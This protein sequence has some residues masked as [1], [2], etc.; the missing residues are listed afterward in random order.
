MKTVIQVLLAIAIVGLSYVLYESIM[1]PIRFNKEKK[2]R[3]DATIQ[4]LK[5]I[6]TCQNAF[7][8]ENQKFT[9]SFDTLIEFIKNGNFKVI[10]Q[11]GSLDDSLAVAMGKVYRDTVKVPVLD[12]L[13]GKNYKIED[14]RFVPYADKVMFQLADS[15]LL[16]GSKVKVP[17]FEC[18]VHNDVLLH[19]MNRQ[20]VVNLNAERKRIDKYPGLKVGS[21]EE[22]NNSAGNWE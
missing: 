10:K 9:G 15:I 21:L 14:L 7:K 12:S 17:V 8:S 6:R 22:A 5:D 18:K 3:Y 16:T 4:R 19:G 11:I 1:K 13:F 2:V 20:L